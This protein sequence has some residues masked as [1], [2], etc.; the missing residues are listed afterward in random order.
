MELKRSSS[1]CGAR[2]TQCSVLNVLCSCHPTQVLLDTSRGL[3]HL[4]SNKVV[5]GD[6][7]AKNV[8][9][10]GAPVDKGFLAKVAD[11]SV[12]RVLSPDLT[13]T[14]AGEGWRGGGGGGGVEGEG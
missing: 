12:S 7:E 13:S 14:T 3:Q 5:H 9:L 6:V 11:F 10:A 2:R 1:T 8:L 4:H